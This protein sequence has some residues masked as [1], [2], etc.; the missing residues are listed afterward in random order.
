M[1]SK[2]ITLETGWRLAVYQSATSTS[3]VIFAHPDAHE[4][5]CVLARQQTKGRGRHGRLWTSAIDD[6]M[7]LSLA[8]MPE[9]DMR[10]WPTLSFVAA[11]SLLDALKELVP[12]LSAGLK[13]PN[14]VLVNRRKIS[15]IL[16]EAK[17]NRLVLGCGV[18]L[19]NA[20]QVSGA[21]FP[22]TDLEAE[23]GVLLDPQEL[24]L[25]FLAHFHYHYKNWQV[26]GFSTQIDL[27]KSQLLFVREK[28]A[29]TQG[30]KRL[31]GIMKG[32]T[33]DGD[34]LLEDESGHITSITTGDVNLLGF[35]DAISD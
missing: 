16:L 24:C 15:G 9:R 1:T 35:V 32:I 6:G 21:S 34:L 31:T 27:Y 29:V 5:L 23:T 19:K 14:D 22:A 12:D 28:I 11:L 18:N 8:L 4:G 3:D 13:W 30:E 7:Y 33:S 17:Q 2:T 26:T 20:P 10:E 25:C